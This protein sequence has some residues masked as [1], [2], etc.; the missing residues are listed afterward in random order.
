[1]RLVI[2]G[3]LFV[4]AA[5]TGCAR[6]GLT[7]QDQELVQAALKAESAQAQRTMVD[8]RTELQ[9]LQKELG[10]SRVAQARL[11]GDLREAQRRL[12][13]TQRLMETQRD[14]LTRTREERDRIANA[15]RDFQGQLAELSRLRQQVATAAVGDQKRLQDMEAALERQAKEIAEMKKPSRSKS[16][17]RSKAKPDKSGGQGPALQ[18]F[19][20]KNERLAPSVVMVSP[21]DG[22]ARTVIVRRGDT[23]WAL[24]HQHGVTVGRL[25]A[26]NELVSNT[27]VPGQELV[28]PDRPSR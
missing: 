5:V 23:L 17:N 21:S 19:G 10:T 16:P 6:N 7:G 3:L 9:G 26:V 24:A 2:W 22:L 25:K 14:E 4:L 12:A 11:E 28:L 13:E 1:M 20:G 27:I 8:L 18:S 15:G